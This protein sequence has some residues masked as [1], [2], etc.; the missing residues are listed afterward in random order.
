M[1]GVKTC[2]WMKINGAIVTVRWCK[3]CGRGSA[4]V[5]SVMTLNMP[6]QSPQSDLS[7]TLTIQEAMR[8]GNLLPSREL[9]A[10]RVIRSMATWIKLISFPRHGV[11]NVLD[12]VGRVMWFKYTMLQSPA[13]LSDVPR[14]FC[15]VSVWINHSKSPD[16]LYPPPPSP[17]PQYMAHSARQGHV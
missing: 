17:S 3:P 5:S 7:L 15:F 8:V 16:V 2:L 6:V 13:V 14:M 4:L 9:C 10:P 11:R 1:I 12:Q